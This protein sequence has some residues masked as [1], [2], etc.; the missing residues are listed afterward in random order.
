MSSRLLDRF[1]RAILAL[2]QGDAR[3][4]AERVG[5]IV[6]LSASAVQR[7]L[8][9][10]REAGIIRADIMLL[11]AK[12]LGW[13]LTIL[14]EMSIDRDRPEHLSDMKNWIS[15]EAAIQQAWYVTGDSD[16]IL[17]VLARHMEDYDALINR[18]LAENQN[19]RK[20]RTSVALSTLKAGQSVP[21]DSE[22]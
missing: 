11:D 19:V 2:A 7:R 15:R 10:M 4:S 6:G 21:V 16:V 12:A 20:F 9:R 17:V 14:V 18:L 22:E 13:P 3:L 1:D 5:E 8:M